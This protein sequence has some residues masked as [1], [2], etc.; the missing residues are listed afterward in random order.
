MTAAPVQVS[1][2]PPQ[3]AVRE[4][5]LPRSRTGCHAAKFLSGAV[6]MAV[7]R[8]LSRWLGDS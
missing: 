2:A 5:G 3:A 7:A 8:G 1:F 6:L 4:A